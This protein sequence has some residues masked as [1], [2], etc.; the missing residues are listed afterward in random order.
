[1]LIP[2]YSTGFVVDSPR[3]KEPSKA[4][5]SVKSLHVHKLGGRFGRFASF[6]FKVAVQF[7]DLHDTPGRMEARGAVRKVVSWSESRSFFF[8]RLRRR[9]AEFDL[10]KQVCM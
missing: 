2:G 10:R 4:P 8:W 3:W 5:L 7:A 1:M 6:I 9:L